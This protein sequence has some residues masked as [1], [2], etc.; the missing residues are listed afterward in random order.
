MFIETENG[1]RV[2]GDQ[3]NECYGQ[4]VMFVVWYQI[5]GGMLDNI[6]EW[7]ISGS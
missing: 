3:G 2:R 4:S 6:E 7:C 5:G 1:A